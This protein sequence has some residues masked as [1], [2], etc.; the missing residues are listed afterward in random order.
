M[1]TREAVF[2]AWLS[3]VRVHGERHGQV[4]YAMLLDF[5]QGKFFL[6][7]SDADQLLRQAEEAGL[8]RRVPGRPE[9]TFSQRVTG[10][11]GGRY[12]DKEAQHYPHLFSYRI[13]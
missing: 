6:D 11:G 1:M 5:A 13:P 10:I 9:P 4:L 8:I 7:S 12:S 2:E 3:Q